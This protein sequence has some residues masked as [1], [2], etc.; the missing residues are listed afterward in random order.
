MIAIENGDGAALD[1]M[2]ALT[3]DSFPERYG[4]G[5]NAYQMRSMLSLPNV[6][7]YLARQEKRLVGFA[8]TRTIMDECELLLIAVSPGHRRQGIGADL[9]QN[10]IE[11]ARSVSVSKLFL[12]MRDGNNAEQLYRRFGFERVGRRLSYYNGAEGIRYDAITL[13][14]ALSN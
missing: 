3:L 2:V 7:A 14:A 10:L 8:I 6:S 1:E 12:E 13:A 4:E 9:V 11:Q 5:W